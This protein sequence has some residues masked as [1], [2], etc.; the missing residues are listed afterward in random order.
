MEYGFATPFACSQDIPDYDFLRAVKEAGFDYVELPGTLIG[1][2]EEERFAYLCRFLEDIGLKCKRICALL[3]GRINFLTYDKAD[4][5]VYVE[6]LFERFSRLGVESIGYGSGMSRN[7]PENMPLPE[8]ESRF[9]DIL[10]KNY[11]PCLVKYGMTLNIEPL[12]TEETNFLNTVRQTALFLE[13]VG[14]PHFGIVADTM[15]MMTMKE[16]PEEISE[17]YLD[18]IGHFHVSEIGRVLPAHSYSTEC[19]TFIRTMLDHGYQKA[20]SFE[21]KCEKI[22]DLKSALTLIRAI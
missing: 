10:V 1:G 14:D 22:E 11:L 6:M 17:K 12:R 8:A 20:I 15:H 21:T 13:K 7:I 3:P 4:Y 19:R 5:R 2:L 9:A 16:K 18:Y